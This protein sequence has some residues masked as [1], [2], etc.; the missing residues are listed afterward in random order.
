MESSRRYDVLRCVVECLVSYFVVAD[1][2]AA[3][4]IAGER[5]SG[6]QNC[7]Q[8]TSCDPPELSKRSSVQ[9]N[10]GVPT[11]CCAGFPCG[12]GRGGGGLREQIY[13]RLFFFFVVRK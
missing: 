7:P 6:E 2:V 9:T 1:G 10:D 13:L 11:G 8:G 3:E 4:D 5:G 12:V